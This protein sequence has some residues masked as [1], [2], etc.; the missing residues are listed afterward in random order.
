MTKNKISTIFSIIK[1]I[2]SLSLLIIL[3]SC[4]RFPKWN[5][6]NQI[7][8]NQDD[9]ITIIGTRNGIS[10]NNG[11]KSPYVITFD[12]DFRKTYEAQFPT[13]TSSLN[14]RLLMGNG[15]NSILSYYRALSLYHQVEHSYLLFL[16]QKL[17]IQKETKYG[18]RTRINSL[19]YFNKDSL[20]AYNYERHKLNTSLSKFQDSIVGKTENFAISVKTNI[21]TDIEAHNQNIFISGIADGYEYRD[22]HEYKAFKTRGYIILADYELKEQ[23]RFV[24]TIKQN[25]IIQDI[26]FHEDE[27]ISTG[28]SQH[29][30]TGIDI[31]IKSFDNDLGINWN[32]IHRKKNPQK[33]IK[34]IDHKGIL[35]VLAEDINQQTGKTNLLL[36]KL[37]KEGRLI[38]E[39][40]IK[41]EG[42]IRAKDFIIHNDYLIVVSN[43]F[44]NRMSSPMARIQKFSLE[45]QLITQRII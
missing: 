18:H 14:P 24:D 5:E 22:G 33:G 28:S 16:D 42:S 41:E 20:L 12:E 40:S 6:V 38:E 26:F 15:K 39:I 35:Y 13:P 10:K 45:G 3:A 27:L 29:Q 37:S 21:P 8:L 43:K 11:I 25:S 23:K 9:Q 4:N 7:V 44:I 30:S 17:N 34:T 31:N 1:Y 19:I 2:S 36:L 32:Y